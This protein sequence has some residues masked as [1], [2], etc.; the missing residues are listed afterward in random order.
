MCLINPRAVSIDNDSTVKLHTVKQNLF[1]NRF[2]VLIAI[3]KHRLRNS[4]DGIAIS[5]EEG[6]ARYR[7]IYRQNSLLARN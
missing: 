6:E 1:I 4:A 2:N 5:M 3:F 7:Q